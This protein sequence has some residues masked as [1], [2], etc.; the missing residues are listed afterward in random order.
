MAT[1]MTPLAD[2]AEYD[3]PNMVKLVT[4]R[5]GGALYF[6]RSPIPASRSGGVP[7]DARRHIGL[8][9][10][11]VRYLLQLAAAPVA[12]PERAERLEQLRALWLGIRIAVADA[13]ET[14][15]RGVDT[16]DDLAFIRALARQSAQQKRLP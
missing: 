1:L 12:P 3:D 4:D 5:S 16:E 6:S 8:Y 7:E 13:V 15:P 2:P 14:P 10:Y 9:A 11:R